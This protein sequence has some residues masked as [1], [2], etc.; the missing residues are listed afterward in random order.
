MVAPAFTRYRDIAFAGAC[1]PISISIV[2]QVQALWITAYFDQDPKLLSSVPDEKRMQE[3][4][5]LHKR[6]EKRRYPDPAGYGSRYL[7][8]VFDTIPYIDIL[9]SDLGLKNWRKNGR[10]A[11]WSEACGHEDY[12][13]LIPEYPGLRK[14]TL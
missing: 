5:V 4:A 2:A 9:L 8:F 1:A 12:K 6:F 13:G 10:I 3:S 7:D 14:M 11:E